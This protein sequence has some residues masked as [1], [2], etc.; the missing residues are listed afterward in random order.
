MRLSNTSSGEESRG[1]AIR[2]EEGVEQ[3][4]RKVNREK[5]K[6]KREK[7]SKGAQEETEKVW[8]V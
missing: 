8:M 6:S 5:N 2:G 1:E 7:E 4:S 3:R